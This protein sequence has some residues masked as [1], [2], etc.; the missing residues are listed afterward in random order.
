MR[1]FL[2]GFKRDLMRHITIRPRNFQLFVAAAARGEC[3]LVTVEPEEVYVFDLHSIST[4]AFYNVFRAT[5][6]DGRTIELRCSG[7]FKGPVCSDD[8]AMRAAAVQTLRNAY[9]GL[10]TIQL[11]L[12]QNNCPVSTRFKAPQGGLLG[13]IK[14]TKPEDLQLHFC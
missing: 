10:E 12:R 3:V 14:I 4:R 1:A 5:T 13:M 7:F 8:K 9:E 2:A 11:W 6:W